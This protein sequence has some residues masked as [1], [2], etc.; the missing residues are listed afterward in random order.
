MDHGFFICI[1]YSL[2]YLL[3]SIVFMSPSGF[4]FNCDEAIRL[5]KPNSDMNNHDGFILYADGSVLSDCILC[6]KK[7]HRIFYI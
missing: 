6:I 4:V 3:F 1:N 2:I 7:I 5:F